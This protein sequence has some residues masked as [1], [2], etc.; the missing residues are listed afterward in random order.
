MEE[1][2]MF[3]CECILCDCKSIVQAIDEAEAPSFCP[4]LGT[5]TEFEEVIQ[6]IV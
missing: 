6:I 5:E 2:V 4:M 1:G 3:E